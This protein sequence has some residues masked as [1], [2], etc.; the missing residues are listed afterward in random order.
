MLLILLLLLVMVG[1]SLLTDNQICAADINADGVINVVDIVAMV[2]MI[3][4]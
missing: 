1:T 3:T 4:G 2:S